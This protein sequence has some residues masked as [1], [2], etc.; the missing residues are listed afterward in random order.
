MV[1]I[2]D[3]VLARYS[4]GGRHFE[5]YVDPD[6]ALEVKQGKEVPLKEL[7]A[8]EEIYKDAKKGDRVAESSLADV[9]GTSDLY[10]VVKQIIQK[11]EIQLTT[12]QR[13]KMVEEKKKAI[14]A[15]ITREAY[16]P[17][18]QTPHP[19]QRIESAMDEA[20]VHVDP[21]KST[22]EQVPGII[23]VIRPII[24]ISIEKLKLEAFIP[25]AYTG[26][27][28]GHLKSFDVQKE[29]W[30]NDGT[31]RIVVQIPAGLENEFYD[32]ING[33]TKGEATFK[34]I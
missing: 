29:D 5:I 8:V 34:K 2:N 6:K 28:Y 17:Q 19:P 7:V 21:F 27:V 23:N 18:T 26:Q 11:G 13:R 9:F 10:P 30:L 20:R 1:S 3:A 22:D 4:Q 33:M 32:K 31:L 25:P 14:I 15:A 12:E 16:N 24:P